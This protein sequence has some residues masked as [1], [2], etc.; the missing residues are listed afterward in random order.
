[1]SKPWA[2]QDAKNR[3]SE[4]VEKARHE[5]AQVITR[6]GTTVAVL[7]SA[8]EYAALTTPST[9]LIA[10]LRRSP[11]KGVKLDLER[12]EDVGRGVDL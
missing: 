6:R 8:E 7:V 2:L 5:G 4:L 12:D 11:L 3:F 1:M 10:F 9:D